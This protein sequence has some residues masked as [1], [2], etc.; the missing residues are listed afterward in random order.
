[1]VVSLE[2]S[3]RGQLQVTAWD[4][5]RRENRYSRRYELDLKRPMLRTRLEVPSG[6]EL[7]LQATTSDPRGHI[8]IRRYDPRLGYRP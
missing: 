7:L 8:E 2:G 4:P 1:M 5:E 3:E 6:C